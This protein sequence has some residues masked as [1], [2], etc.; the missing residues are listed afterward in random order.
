MALGCNKQI[1]FRLFFAK[2]LCIFPG[3]SETHSPL[4]ILGLVWLWRPDSPSRIAP[5]GPIGLPG[6]VFRDARKKCAVDV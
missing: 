6:V 3:G 5:G 2:F 4:F 1:N